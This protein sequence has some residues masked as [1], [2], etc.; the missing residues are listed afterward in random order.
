MKTKNDKIADF[1]GLTQGLRNLDTGMTQM[2]PQLAQL[3]QQ[4]PL[5]EAQAGL[6]DAQRDQL[7][8][9]MQMSE[10]M[11]PHEIDSIKSKNRYYGAQTDAQ[12][13]ELDRAKKNRG[14]L[15]ELMGLGLKGKR[16]ENLMQLLG[17]LTPVEGLLQN[18]PEHLQSLRQQLMPR[19]FGGLSAQHQ[20]QPHE[21]LDPQALIEFARTQTNR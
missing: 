8:Q 9:A 12:L 13:E 14:A 4:R 19:L 7:L 2:L 20:P 15:D 16:M 1:V 18:E 6:T 11:M 17:L 5:D 21:M 3:E 10:T